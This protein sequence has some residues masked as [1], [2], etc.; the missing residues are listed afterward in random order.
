MLFLAPASVASLSLQWGN[1]VYPMMIIWVLGSLILY[2]L[3][4]LHITVTY[5]TSFLVLA[6]VRSQVTGYSWLTEIAPITG[7]MYQLYIFF[8]ITDPKTTTR[9]KWS[10]CLV[11]VFIAVA[12]LIFR[13]NQ[14]VNAPYYALFVVG[15]AANLVEIWWDSHHPATSRPK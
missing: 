14:V 6:L 8:M 13:L 10:Q 1:E 9:R 7:P 15:P 5:V 12:E 11:A 4:F 2:R 3:G